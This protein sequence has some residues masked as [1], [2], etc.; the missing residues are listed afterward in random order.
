M[1]ARREA[2]ER[3]AGQY[4]TMVLTEALPLGPTARNE[5]GSYYLRRFYCTLMQANP[6]ARVYLYQTWV[7]FQ[8]TDPY[9]KFPPPHRFDWHAEMTAQR[10]V[11]EELA[12]SAARPGVRAPGR[13]ERFG[14][15]STSDGG[16]NATAPIFIVPVGQALVALSDRLSKPTPND[17]L[18]WPDGA[19]LRMADFFSNAYI[20]WPADWPLGRGAADIDSKSVV[21][22]LTRKDPSREH[23]D[24]HASALGIYFAALVHFATLYRQ[25]P[26]GLAA[27]ESIGDGL[28]RALQCLAWTTVVG[29]PYAG[30]SG[31]PGC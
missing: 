27:P 2:F 30:V 12:A 25:T 10:A 4:D 22:K 9:A 16:C 15:T 17:A 8:G 13:L 26:V 23:D 18:A 1:V 6:S 5:Y 29:D 11:W 28:A 19:R 3:T 14:W 7:N 20:D 31:E 24:I 21:A